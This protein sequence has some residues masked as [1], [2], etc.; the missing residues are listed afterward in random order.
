MRAVVLAVVLA[1]AGCKSIQWDSPLTYT[2]PETGEV[3]ETTVGNAVADRVDDVGSVVGS[4]AGKA[5]GAA[6]GNPVV[7]VSASA[8]LA[9]LIASGTSRLRRKKKG[10][11]APGNDTAPDPTAEPSEGA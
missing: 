3:V 8:L 9:A 4:V 10:A 7:G 2:D 11:G 5:L 1:S 6:T